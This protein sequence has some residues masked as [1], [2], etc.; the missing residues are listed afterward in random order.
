MARRPFPHA[1][2]MKRVICAAHAAGERVER[3]EVHGDDFIVVLAPRNMLPES[4]IDPV[5]CLDGEA[6]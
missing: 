5:K 1:G 3:L 2:K 6:A 4:E